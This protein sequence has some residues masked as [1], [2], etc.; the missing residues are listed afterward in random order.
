L[1]GRY[2]RNNL[3]YTFTLRHYFLSLRLQRGMKPLDFA[4][5]KQRAGYLVGIDLDAYKSQQMDRRLHS[6]MSLWEVT[7][8]D[9]YYQILMSNPARLKEFVDKLTINVSEFFR[10]SDRFEVLRDRIIPELLSKSAALRIW[11]AGC[12]NGSEP[13]SVAILLRELTGSHSH[14]ILGTDVD[15]QILKKAVAGVYHPNEV[16]AVEPH[17]LEKYFT[18]DGKMYTLDREIVADVHFKVHNLLKDEFETNFD[19]IIC[20]NVVIYFTEQAKNA[21]Y[22]RFWDSLKNHGYLFVGGTEPLLNSKKFGFDTTITGFY[23]KCEKGPEVDSYWQQIEL[24]RKK[25]RE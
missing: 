1:F 22:Y 24:L 10:N 18:F 20:R 4:E 8:Y 9:E 6:L 15:A 2:N 21:L 13:Y 3:E 19:L 5:F 17:L 25:V 11:S 23:R 14:Y 12:S 7:S 16:R